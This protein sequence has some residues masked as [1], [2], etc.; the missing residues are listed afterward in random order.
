MLLLTPL[1]HRRI[2]RVVLVGVLLTLVSGACTSWRA[3]P[4]GTI[5]ADRPSVVRVRSRTGDPVTLRTPQLVAD[6]VVGL[7]GRD[8]V[9]IPVDDVDGIDLP[10]VSAM[11]TSLLVFGVA[12]FTVPAVG[13]FLGCALGECSGNN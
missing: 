2:A 11:R 9:G 13:L 6:S 12:L 10:R 8:R 1:R 5:S 3:V 7:D 4:V